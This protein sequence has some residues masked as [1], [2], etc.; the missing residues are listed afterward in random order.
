[1]GQERPRDHG[2]VL[3][4]ELQPRLVVLAVHHPTHHIGLVTTFKMCPVDV[5]ETTVTLRNI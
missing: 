1:M 4:A 3:E 2:D 5:F